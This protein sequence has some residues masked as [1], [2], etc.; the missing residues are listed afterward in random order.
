MPS[1][2][3]QSHLWSRENIGRNA[4]GVFVIGGIAVVLAALWFFFPQSHQTSEPL[5]GQLEARYR[6]E[7]GV[8][9]RTAG[10]SPEATRCSYYAKSFALVCQVAPA[11]NTG[12][13]TA[14][15]QSGW[16][17]SQKSGELVFIRERDTASVSCSSPVQSELCEFTLRYRLKNADA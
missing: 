16:V 15:Q 13:Q 2:H 4:I 14:L 5:M 10:L 6:A 9:F 1:S 3:P 12:L 7:S 11:A 17:A 8:L